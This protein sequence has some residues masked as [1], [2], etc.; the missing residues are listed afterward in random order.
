MITR[1]F[2]ILLDETGRHP[3]QGIIECTHLKDKIEHA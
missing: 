3:W 2:Y 1:T